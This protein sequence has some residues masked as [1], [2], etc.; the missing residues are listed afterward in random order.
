MTMIRFV[1][2]KDIVG[3]C[4]SYAHLTSTDARATIV[5]LQGL[6]LGTGELF[7]GVNRCH[8]KTHSVGEIMTCPS[9]PVTLDERCCPKIF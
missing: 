3:L 6:S 2:L 4:S 9:R 8:P 5:F 7:I 1:Y